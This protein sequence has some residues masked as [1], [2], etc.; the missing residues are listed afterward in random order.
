MSFATLTEAMNAFNTLIEKADGDLIKAQE[1]N[2][3]VNGVIRIGTDLEALSGRVAGV[4]TFVG[5]DET[6]SGD[7]LKTRIEALEGYVGQADD[8]AD[9]GTL[10]GR[11]AALEGA[12]NVTQEEHNELEA[13]IAP[14]LEQ[15]T[16]T[17]ETD[18]TDYL[19]GDTATVT[20]TVRTLTGEIPAGRPWID[21]IATWGRIK[22]A[23]GFT[24]REDV[25]NR[26][27]SVRT[28]SE[29]IARVQVT[30]EQNKH[31]TVEEE[32]EIS[33]FFRMELPTEPILFSEAVKGAPTTQ[34]E[35]MALVFDT[36]T[37]EY[38]S[39]RQALG[40][41]IDD[42]YLEKSFGDRWGW[43]WPQSR[44]EY[45][46]CTLVGFAKNDATP[47]T[48][49]QSRGVASIQILFK[50]WI[51]PWVN[52]YLAV[53]DDD[54]LVVEW[55]GHL[56]GWF[57]TEPENIYENLDM[58]METSIFQRGVVYRQKGLKAVA[59][60]TEQVDGTVIP[61][62]GEY[63]KDVIRTAAETQQAT[64]TL[65]F[66][67]GGPA[68]MGGGPAMKAMFAQGRQVDGVNARVDQ[69][70]D[71]VLGSSEIADI[72]GA[73]DILQNSTTNVSK[74]IMV[75]LSDI[76]NKVVNINAF[77]SESLQTSVNE[78]KAHIGVTRNI[79]PDI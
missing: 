36:A 69:T 15:Y 53:E 34:S 60:A 51:S 33:Q 59:K 2:D 44:W 21:F 11:V 70:K 24:D 22:A 47:T 65:Q 10:T 29:G 20:A 64:D 52:G 45:Y 79:V 58:E 39:N 18:D 8:A 75:A 49:D 56:Q 76:E 13:S 62:K 63:I 17:F 6:Y 30:A 1:W 55:G 5:Y 57:N 66:A 73:V 46:R 19:L 23:P 26:S 35:H 31:L 74:D 25:G 67:A 43:Q 28:N 27:V 16:V 7:D 40:R 54:D 77:D 14:L 38:E 4:E 37:V 61:D 50:D 32:L 78:I 3:L 41:L 42:Y 72:K 48:P 68:A 71:E 12:D 9:D